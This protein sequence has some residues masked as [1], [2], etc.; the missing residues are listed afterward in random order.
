MT[1]AQ[2]INKL[3]P[4]IKSKILFCTLNT[5]DFRD[6]NSLLGNYLSMGD[7]IVVHMCGSGKDLNLRKTQEYL[8]LTITDNGHGRAFVKKV[9]SIDGLIEDMIKP[10]DHIAAINAESTVGLR[11]YE[12]AKTI[13]E[14]P[15]KTNFTLHLVEPLYSEKN[16]EKK[17]I[18]L[19]EHNKDLKNNI[20]LL[21]FADLDYKNHKGNHK[22]PNNSSFNSN[23]LQQSSRPA[24]DTSN[25]DSLSSYE[26]LANSSLPIERLLSKGAFTADNNTHSTR[27]ELG[28]NSNVVQLDSYRT[29]IE[30]INSILESFLGINDNLLAIQIY[31]LAKENKD[32]ITSFSNAIQKSELNVF[33]FDKDIADH[34][35]KCATNGDYDGTERIK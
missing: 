12:V 23:I 1:S 9:K 5:H 22:D 19:V 20:S 32:S 16:L 7:L 18:K 4:Q 10:G 13:R 26:D 29:T 33:N 27:S 28:A 31:R 25:L 30:R 24:T 14:I 21:S 2:L 8:G 11:H 6:M 35:W 3:F 15:E 17:R 34:L